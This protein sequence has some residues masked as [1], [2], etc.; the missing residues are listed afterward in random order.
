M[1]NAANMASAQPQ[2]SC[3]AGSACMKTRMN[4]AKTAVLVA[5]D[6]KPVTGVGALDTSRCP[7]VEGHHGDL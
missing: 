4:A 7:H 5:T 1:V 3:V 6:M 2:V